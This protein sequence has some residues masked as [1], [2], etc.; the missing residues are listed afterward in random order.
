METWQAINTIRV[1]REFDDRPLAPEHLDRILN[2][3]RRTA[4]SKNQQEWAF[5][6]V[7]DREHL[8]ELTRVGRYADHLAGAAVA[9]A[10][11][12]AGPARVDAALGPGPRRAEHGAGGLGA[13]NRQRARHVP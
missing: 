1:I 3:A 11:G 7:R 4:S 5:I 2:A 13:G 6:V 10:P 12:D 8:K 9:I